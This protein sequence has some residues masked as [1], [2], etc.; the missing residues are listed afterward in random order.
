MILAV[1]VA[2]AQSAAPPSE[3]G[4]PAE[5][6]RAPIVVTGERNAAERVRDFVGALTWT[7]VGRQLARFEQSVCPVAIGLAKPQAQTVSQRIRRVAGTVGIRVGGPGCAPNIV[8]VVTS[9]KAAFLKELRR[10]HPEYFGD[11]SSSRVR[12]LLRQPGPATAW[13]LN[14][15]PISARGT[16]LTVDP[17]LDLYVNRTSEPA[18]RLSEP[19]RPQFDASVLIVERR[20]LTGLTA[21]QLA[22]Y[23]ALRTLTGAR[24]ER[25]SANSAPTILTL[26]D[27]PMGAP[28]PVTMTQWDLAFLRG[29]YASGRNVNSASQRS[30]IRRSMSEDISKS[31]EP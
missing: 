12:A 4:V 31:P 6:D 15:P 11:L 25:L 2:L 26:L 5:S 3:T 16:E 18:S 7:P 29:Y 27:T 23:A 8:V 24:P 1:A 28:V 9:D 22:D 13:Q 10:R 14:G 17:S 30:Q 21:T 20:A 19:A